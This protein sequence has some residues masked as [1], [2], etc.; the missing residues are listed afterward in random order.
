MSS[1]L[2]AFLLSLFQVLESQLQA[3]IA[4]T[5]MIDCIIYQK[6]SFILS[7]SL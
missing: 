6:S 5:E 4:F 3:C 2:Y 1:G 7:G